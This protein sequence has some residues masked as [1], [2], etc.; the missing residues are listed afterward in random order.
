MATT[1]RP[2][3]LP[4]KP[5]DTGN[6]EYKDAASSTNAYTKIMAMLKEQDA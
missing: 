2:R 4:T 5:K 1:C 3:R 6:D